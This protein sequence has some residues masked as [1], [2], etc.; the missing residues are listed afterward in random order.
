MYN[1]VLMP[2]KGASQMNLQNN[3]ENLIGEFLV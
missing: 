2:R 3:L 1:D